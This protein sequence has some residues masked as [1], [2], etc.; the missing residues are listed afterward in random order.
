MVAPTSQDAIEVGKVLADKLKPY[1]AFVLGVL[2]LLAT[3]AVRVYDIGVFVEKTKAHEDQQDKNLLKLKEVHEKHV[4]KGHDIHAERDR[5]IIE[6]LVNDLALLRHMVVELLP[7]NKR[8]N[9]RRQF[10][11][12]RK[13]ELQLLSG[14]HSR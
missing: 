12:Q 14:R 11:A 3:G 10:E 1:R 8:D 7:R 4:E 6:V 5:E 9:A 2:G 13:A